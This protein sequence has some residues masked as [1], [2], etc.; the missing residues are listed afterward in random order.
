M[1]PF[2]REIDLIPDTKKKNKQT[3]TKHTL[4]N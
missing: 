2:N 1:I 4:S 3:K